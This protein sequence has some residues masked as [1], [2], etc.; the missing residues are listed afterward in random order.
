MTL[1]HS[2]L[3]WRHAMC[4]GV[5]PWSSTSVGSQPDTNRSRHTFAWFVITA[6]WRGVWVERGKTSSLLLQT[7]GNNNDNNKKSLR[8]HQCG[9]HLS[10]VVLYV[11]EL[12]VAR[13]VDHCFDVVAGLVDDGQVEQP[14]D[15]QVI[16]SQFSS[17]K[18]MQNFL[19]QIPRHTIDL[20]A[21]F[22]QTKKL[23]LIAI[24]YGF[25]MHNTVDNS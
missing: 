8:R 16:L 23:L 22:H 6:R 9:T 20:R 3:P 2:R 14:A 17:T 12:C 7:G 11:E 19:Q 25:P 5:S 10:L 21:F 4:R 1:K 13:Q 18:P 24:N 15:S